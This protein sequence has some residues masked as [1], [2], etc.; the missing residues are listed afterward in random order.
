MAISHYSKAIELYPQ[1]TH[2]YA[3][4]GDAYI[5]NSQLA[6]GIQDCTHA[7]ALDP[8][9]TDAYVNR[10]VAHCEN[11]EIDSGISDFYGALELDAAT[12][13]AYLGLGIAFGENGNYLRSIQNLQIALEMEPSPETYS[14]LGNAYG[15]MGDLERAVESYTHALTLVA[16]DEF[17]HYDRAEVFLRQGEWDSAR[18]D[19]VTA[20]NLGA[21]IA[22]LFRNDYAGI[23]DFEERNSL[24][25]PLDIAEML[26][27]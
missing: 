2:A 22:D 23:S 8:G 19:L 15:H 14:A 21:D 5:E 12:V 9:L 20:R 17:C 27:G 4:R 18:A 10:G 16:D 7:L 13:G 3:Q 26:A 25:L 6:E 24:S 11:G 1:F